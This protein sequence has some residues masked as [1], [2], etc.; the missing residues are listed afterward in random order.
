MVA[1]LKP[2]LREALVETARASFL[3]R[4]AGRQISPRVSARLSR[5]VMFEE[6]RCIVEICLHPEDS[7]DNQG[8]AGDLMDP[9]SIVLVRIIVDADNRVVSFE[10]FGPVPW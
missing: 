3:D 8:L 6:T 1:K 4:Y 7:G 9:V 10:E 5:S 2:K